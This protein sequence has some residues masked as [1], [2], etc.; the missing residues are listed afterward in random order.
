MTT[1]FDPETT[2]K[3][4]KYL[5]EKR[6]TH[7]WV[8]GEDDKWCWKLNSYKIWY[9]QVMLYWKKGL[10]EQDE[11]YGLRWIRRTYR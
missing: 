5:A 9:N 1:I 3:L 6:E 11:G 8:K 10:Y 4:S 7:D 2:K